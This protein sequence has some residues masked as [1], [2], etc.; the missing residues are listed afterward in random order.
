MDV[1]ILL[2]LPKTLAE[3]VEAEGLLSASELTG[4]FER[5]LERRRSGRSLLGMMDALQSL[6]PRLSEEEIE[7][8]LAKAK[9]ERIAAYEQSR[10]SL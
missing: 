7:A 10:S 5:E 6:E 3:E 2:T 1:E 9:A 4:I 8:E